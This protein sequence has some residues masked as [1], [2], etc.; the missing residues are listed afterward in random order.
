[1]HGAADRR[2]DLRNREVVD[3]AQHQCQT[4]IGRHPVEQGG[5][6]VVGRGI[7]PS[8]VDRVSEALQTLPLTTA[9]SSDVEKAVPRH[10]LQPGDRRVRASA[11]AQLTV[12]RDVRVLN[13]VFGQ[14]R[15]RPGKTRCVAV[16]LVDGRFEQ[17]RQLLAVRHPLLPSRR[18]PTR[19]SHHTSKTSAEAAFRRDTFGGVFKG[20]PDEAFDFYEGLE[21]DNSR[22]YWL[23][24]KAVYDE[25]VK[26]PIVALAAEFPEYGDFHVFR[27]NRDVRFS[28]NKVPYKTAQGAVAG[29]GAAGT[30][31]QIS[32]AGLMAARGYYIM[33]PDQLARFRAAVA[34]DRTGPEVVAI[35]DGLRNAGYD[36]GARDAVKSAP[37][38]YAADHPRIALLRGKGLMMSRSWPPA[39]WVGTKAVV[40]KVRTVWRDADPLVAW[41]DR[42]VGH[43]TEPLPPRGGRR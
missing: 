32:A 22:V 15:V 21:A 28:A 4:L 25:A 40:G 38:G 36:V 33:V 9:P 5:G 16:Q 29:D 19:P 6:R 17:P 30:Y 10:A 13:E 37:R 34:D 7:H 1:M 14:H 41:L 26:A 3:V 27:P 11:A 23:D 31:V 43:S 2:R 20:F 42:H 18:G 35:V 39:R 24:H 12:E 8:G